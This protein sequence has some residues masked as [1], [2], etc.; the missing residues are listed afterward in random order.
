MKSVKI[1]ND[2]YLPTGDYRLIN[3]Q[4]IERAK[5]TLGASANDHQLLIEYDK[6]AGLILDENNK[7]LE[8]HTFWNIEKERLA[9][10]QIQKEKFGK[11]KNLVK[12]FIEIIKGIKAIVWFIL[13]IITLLILILK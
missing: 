11:I 3:D 12:S 8:P 9:R 10:K 5:S 2:D 4:K 6:I 7:K 13:F 1:K